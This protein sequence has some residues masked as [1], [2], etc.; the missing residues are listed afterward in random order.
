MAGCIY[1][2]L[3]VVGAWW[4]QMHGGNILV[5]HGHATVAMEAS[6]WPWMCHGGRGCLMVAGRVVPV[7]V[8]R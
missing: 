6:Q 4:P 2:S 1:G 8:P 5:G 3:M 7:D